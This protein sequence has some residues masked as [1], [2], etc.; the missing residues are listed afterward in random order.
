MLL[1]LIANHINFQRQPICVSL[2]RRE[3]V[4]NP[5]RA[6]RFILS[7]ARA[8]GPQAARLFALS[9]LWMVRRTLLQ[10]TRG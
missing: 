2:A 3:R 7:Q 4:F 1:S 10:E 8:I 5:S 9:N 6:T